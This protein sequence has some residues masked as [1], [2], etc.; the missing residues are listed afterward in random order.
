MM[1]VV[2]LPEYWSMCP[3]AWQNFISVGCHD[4][5]CDHRGD[6]LE[7]FINEQLASY[8]AV[9]SENDQNRLC[10]EFASRDDWLMWLLRWT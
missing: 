1:H 6:V 3:P 7:D 9:L 10:V 5:P 4:S 2:E 8:N